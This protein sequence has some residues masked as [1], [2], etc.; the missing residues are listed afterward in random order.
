MRAL[1]AGT[2]GLVTW[3]LATDGARREVAALRAAG[4][5][6]GDPIPGSRARPDGEVVAGSAPSRPGLGPTEPPFLIEHEL[7]RA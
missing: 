7:A 3:A 5:P 4:S 1:D 2:P 6:I